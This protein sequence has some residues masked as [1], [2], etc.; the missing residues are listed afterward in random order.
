MPPENTI[1]LRDVYELVETVR[2]EAVEDRRQTREYLDAM[3]VE[4]RQGFLAVTEEIN[5]KGDAKG[6][7]GRI[8]DLEGL[9][10]VG[11]SLQLLVT[12]IASTIAALIG[13]RR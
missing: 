1:G 2:R 12:L 9:A 3:R 4:Y 7:K 13:A 8:R 10:A 11:H 5:G 6:M